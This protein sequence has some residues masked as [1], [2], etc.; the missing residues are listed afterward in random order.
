MSDLPTEARERHNID[1][2]TESRGHD[3][4]E[5]QEDADNDAEPTL[6]DMMLMRESSARLISSNFESSEQETT[7]S[8]KRREIQAIIRDS[9]LTDLERRLKI[10]NLMDGRVSGAGTIG[11]CIGGMRLDG[12]S[13]NAAGDDSRDESVSC[14]HY[15]R[16][17][18]I[19]AP[20]CGKI[21]GC[22]VCHDEA[23]GHG[24]MDRFAIKEI[25]CE[26]CKTR[27]KPS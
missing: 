17:C 10:Q 19:V 15:E 16:N 2:Q 20:C 8:T 25:I 6:P 3:E 4:D 12:S 24:P 26:K 14:P 13:G 21:F 9:S 7:L 23:S 5:S 1:M 22:R 11:N 27:Q 18:K